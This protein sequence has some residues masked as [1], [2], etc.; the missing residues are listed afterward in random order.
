MTPDPAQLRQAAQKRIAHLTQQSSFTALRE[1]V[2]LLSIATN[3]LEGGVIQMCTYERGADPRT[4]ALAFN[5]YARPTRPLDPRAAAFHQLSDAFLADMPPF[6]DGFPLLLKHL[7][8][9]AVVVWNAPFVQGALNRT[10]SEHELTWTAPDTWTDLQALVSAAQGGW[11]DARQ[12]FP[13]LSLSEVLRMDGVRARSPY[14]LGTAPGNAAAIGAR[15]LARPLQQGSVPR[16]GL[17]PEQ[18]S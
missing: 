7:E 8:D 1:D 11:S 6:T 2:T 4:V 16:P 10:A 9:R 12:D 13:R 14:A 18:E 3:G 15:L 17:R 5:E